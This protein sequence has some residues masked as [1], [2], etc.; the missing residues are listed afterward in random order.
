M[1]CDISICGLPLP[2]STLW[3]VLSASVDFLFQ[4]GHYGLC[5]LHLWTSC[6]NQHIM[7]CAVSICRPPVPTRTLWTVLH[8]PS[9]NILCSTSQHTKK[10]TSLS[11]TVTAVE[12]LALCLFT[13]ATVDW[14]VNCYETV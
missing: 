13:T 1:D 2:A 3:T 11:A 5:C 7:D 6:S 4:P 9:S 14:T 8:D 10:Q 12:V